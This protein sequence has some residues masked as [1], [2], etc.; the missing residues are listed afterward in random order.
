VKKVFKFMWPENDKHLQRLIYL[1]YVLMISNILVSSSIPYVNKLV[2]NALNQPTEAGDPKSPQSYIWYLVT[3]FFGL[4][5]FQG[6][7]GLLK[8]AQSYVLIPINQYTQRYL[9]THTF[10][11]VHHLSLDFH[12]KKKSGEL[13]KIIDRGVQSIGFLN[14]YIVFQLLPIF[15]EIGVSAIVVLFTM[16][17]IYSIILS[18]TMLFYAWATIAITEWRTKFRKSMIE[19][20][21]RMSSIV[22]D[23]LTNFETVKYFNGEKYELERLRQATISY[24][25]DEFKTNVSLSFLNLAQNFIL[26][27]GQLTGSLLVVYQISRK[28]ADIG[29][30]VM[31]QTYFLNLATPLNF[32]GTFYRII[33][34]SAIDMDKL[35][36]LLDQ[37]PSVREDPA[38]A[39]L[40][41]GPG[42]IIFDN[43]TFGYQPGV[44]TL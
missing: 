19:K 6:T 26:V 1:S 5:L 15:L 13:V 43:V 25:Q 34:Q 24:Q 11:H 30:F 3:F 40:I 21:N 16:N 7:N 18:F 32:F 10:N 8:S 33:Q 9:S 44:P 2:I 37:K 28:Q 12:I 29:D 36:G 14:N 23:S 38:S 22:I 35:V 42:E 41:P 20:E 27:I 39:P 4:K 17:Y 31:F